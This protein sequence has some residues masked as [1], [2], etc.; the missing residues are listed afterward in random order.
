M[1]LNINECKTKFMIMSWHLRILQNLTVDGYTFEQVEDF[2]YLG[3]NLKNMNDM[4]NKIRLRLNV[5]NCGY[6]AM[7]KLFSSK[8]L[9]RKTKRKLYISYLRPIVVWLRNVVNH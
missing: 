6:Y 5:A 1:G 3:I 9:S 7:S 8:L 2:K 4:H